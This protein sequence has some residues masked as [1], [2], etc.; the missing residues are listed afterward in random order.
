MEGTPLHEFP[1]NLFQVEYFIDM[2][3]TLNYLFHF[4]DWNRFRAVHDWSTFER[5]PQEQESE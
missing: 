2:F 5:Q 4:W 1:E 3:Y